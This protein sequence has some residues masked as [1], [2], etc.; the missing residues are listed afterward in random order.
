LRDDIETLALSIALVKGENVVSD[1]ARQ[2]AE[3]QVDI[4][5]TRKSRAAILNKFYN[6]TTKQTS[7][8]ELNVSLARLERYE[9]RAVS[10]RKRALRL[11]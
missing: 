4:L 1:L 5:R 9:R 6:S 3:A 7:P 10:R 2:A 11:M 8:D